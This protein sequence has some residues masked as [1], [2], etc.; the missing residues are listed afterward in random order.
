[1]HLYTKS[2]LIKKGISFMKK[3]IKKFVVWI[4]VVLL[5]IPVVV[6]VG[7]LTKNYILTVMHKDQVE[8][9]QF[10]EYEEDPYLWLDWYRITSYSEDRIEIYYVNEFDDYKM[11][12]HVM[13]GYKI[14]GKVTL[15]Y[16]SSGWYHT[17][18]GSV[19]WSGAGSADNYIW[20]YWYH[21]FLD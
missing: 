1:M 3:T 7:A 4:V 16:N 18:T 10:S 15:Y 21:I 2:V 8:N 5:A 17:D 12:D 9:I 19:L 6:W 11:G 20:P 13:E 14:G